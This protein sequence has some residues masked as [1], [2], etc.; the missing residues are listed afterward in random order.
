MYISVSCIH[1]SNN[2]K[3]WDIYGP[4]DDDVDDHVAENW[5]WCR[6]TERN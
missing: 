1:T 4:N 6:T 3:T 2:K 5:R